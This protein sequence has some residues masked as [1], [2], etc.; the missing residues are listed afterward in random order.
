[1]KGKPVRLG[2]G[3]PN[4]LS[5]TAG[6]LAVGAWLYDRGIARP[7]AQWRIDITLDAEVRTRKFAEALDTRFQLVVLPDEWGFSFWHA[8]QLSRIRVTDLVRPDLRDDH[9]L[10]TMTPP[11]RRIGT[12]VRQLEAR[13]QRQLIRDD[14][15]IATSVPGSE[16]IV[17]AWVETL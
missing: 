6:T 5:P 8:G 17:R 2:M 9:H 13:C 15:E 3:T 1:V 7:P 10:A 16:T 11:L 14:A 12:L 4:G